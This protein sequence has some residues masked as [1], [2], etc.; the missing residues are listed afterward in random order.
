MLAFFFCG[1]ENIEGKTEEM[2]RIRR[3]EMAKFKKQGISRNTIHVFTIL[4]R[5]LSFYHPVYRTS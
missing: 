2:I 3:I 5:P 4:V 1:A